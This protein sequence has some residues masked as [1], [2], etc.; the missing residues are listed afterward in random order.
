MFATTDKG[1]HCPE[2][3]FTEKLLP[4]LVRLFPE[5]KI[6]F[7]HVD[8]AFPIRTDSYRI[9]FENKQSCRIEILRNSAGGLSLVIHATNPHLCTP[10]SNRFKEAYGLYL[11]EVEF[12]QGCMSSVSH[13]ATC[14]ACG[15]SD[16]S[17]VAFSNAPW[18]MVCG[19]RH[20]QVSFIDYLAD[21]LTAAGYTCE[22]QSGNGLLVYKV[23]PGKHFWS[24]SNK[25]LVL[26]MTSKRY[27]D[28]SEKEGELVLEV[29]YPQN[30]EHPDFRQVGGLIMSWMRP[31]IRMIG[32][33]F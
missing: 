13:P 20:Y 7:I 12:A 4:F 14:P 22:Y 24:F 5:Y 33:A 21:K 6:T 31:R 9:D 15:R 2:C 17:L 28:K 23:T 19:C 26:D 29:K 1:V 32:V 11:H 10:I 27:L 8:R 16:T 30:G 18:D 3:R 25:Q